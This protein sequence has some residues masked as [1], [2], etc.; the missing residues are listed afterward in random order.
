MPPL[1]SVILP[2]YNVGP[3]VSAAIQ[4]ILDQSLTDFELIIIDD[5]STDHT[6]RLIEEFSDQRIRLVRKDKNTGLIESLN[7]GLALCRGKFIARMDGD[8]ISLAGR[9]EKQAA[10]LE[11]HPDIAIC[12]TWY[13]LSNSGELV[14]NPVTNAE[15]RIALLDYCALGHPTVMLRNSFLHQEQLFYDSNFFAAEDYDLWTRIVAMGK[16]ANLPEVLLLYRMHADQVSVKD[17]LSQVANAERCRIRMLL[18]V[19]SSPKAED[20]D[21]CRLLVKKEKVGNKEKLGAILKWLDKV[22]ENN[23]G[24]GFYDPG[25]F[26]VFI[27][28]KKRNLIRVFFLHTVMYRPGI[29][30][31]SLKAAYRPLSY[32]T[33]KEQAKFILKCLVYKQA[34]SASD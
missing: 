12:G 3:F 25:L 34:N 18:Y 9:L 19:I 13:K 30:Y 4:S 2:V 16:I 29:L 17:Q 10:F 1:V 23:L 27:N 8:D 5:C 7:H 11:A 21:F 32:F 6:L 14:K 15:I 24:S 31:Y 33:F 20:L 28:N 26:S 22:L